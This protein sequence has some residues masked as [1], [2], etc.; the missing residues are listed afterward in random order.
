MRHVGLMLL[1][2]AAFVIDLRLGGWSSSGLHPVLLDV[3]LLAAMR[4]ELSAAT[5][6]AGATIGCLAAI[7]EGTHP[8]WGVIGGSTAVFLFGTYFAGN[9]SRPGGTTIRALPVLVAVIAVRGVEVMSA[10][11]PQQDSLSLLWRLAGNMAL[12]L[13]VAS[14]AVVLIDIVKPRPSRI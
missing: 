5:L 11:P 13:L 3:V 1:I 8:G 12:T 7:V 2:Y 9:E 14:V 4:C 6:L 10:H